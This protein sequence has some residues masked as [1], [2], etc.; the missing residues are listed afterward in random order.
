MAIKD[1]FLAGIL[2]HVPD[3]DRGKAEAA[4]SGLEE[5]GLRQSEFSKLADDA[6]AAEQR[7]KD[8]YE[9]N[10]QWLEERKAAL[11]DYDA[12][13]L[14]VV[15]LRKRPAAGAPVELP[16]DLITEK[17]LNERIEALERGAVG[18]IA[19]VPK[20]A[21]EHYQR[22]GEVLDTGMLLADKRVQQIGIQGVYNEVFKDKLA[23]KAKEATDARDETLRK[24]GEERLRGTIRQQPAY[25]VVGNEPSALDAIEA[26]RGGQKPQVA[27]VDQM[28]DA[29]SR[30]STTRAGAS[31]H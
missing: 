17:V 31:A 19:L 22:F 11:T 8:L 5:N 9:S 28:A 4:I 3:A 14:E 15:D 21:V 2:A 30:L 1:A 26:E 6:K 10:V 23:L 29:Y 13:K 18:V 12:L 20:L 7:F 16:K 27:T 25:P 24:E